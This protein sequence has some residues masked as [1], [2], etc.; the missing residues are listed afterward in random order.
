MWCGQSTMR[1]STPLDELVEA[2]RPV[3]PVVVPETLEM[4][5]HETPCPCGL[6]GDDRF[7]DVAV[8]VVDRRTERRRVH[9]DYDVLE[10]DVADHPDEELEHAVVDER[11]HR[12]V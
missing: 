2:C 6:T 3:R 10:H 7:G 4:F 9:P 12:A 11:L 1:R 5:L 8:I